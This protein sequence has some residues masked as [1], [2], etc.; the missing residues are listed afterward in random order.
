MEY[1]WYCLGCV[2]GIIIYA[3]CYSVFLD[4]Q[5]SCY[6]REKTMELLREFRPIEPDE[7]KKDKYPPVSPGIGWGGA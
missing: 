4:Y 7:D 3:V 1:L 2:I 5:F 6:K